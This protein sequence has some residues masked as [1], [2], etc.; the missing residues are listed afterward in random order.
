MTAAG[1]EVVVVVVATAVGA[2]GGGAETTCEIGSET[3]LAK[4]IAAPRAT[5][6]PIAMTKRKGAGRAESSDVVVSMARP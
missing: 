4:N 2:A 3:Q 1:V 6:G 5:T